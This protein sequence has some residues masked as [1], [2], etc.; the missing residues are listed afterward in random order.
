MKQTK[1]VLVLL[2]VL[3]VLSACS[4]NESD[5]NNL[6]NYKKH[7]LLLDVKLEA[8]IFFSTYD[9]EVYIDDNKVGNIKQGGSFKNSYSLNDGEHELSFNKSGDRDVNG[10]ISI[11]VDEDKAFLCNLK[12]HRDGIDINDQVEE[13]L[14]EYNIKAEKNKTEPSKTETTKPTESESE[15]I[16]KQLNALSGK[17]LSSVLEKTRIKGYKTKYIATNTGHDLT[18]DIDDIAY[19]MYFKSA[20]VNGKKKIITVKIT[21]KFIIEDRKKEKKL[22][23]KL[24]KYDAWVAAE[25]H[26]KS[27]YKKFNLHYI[28]SP[29]RA[30][31]NKDGT[32]WLLKAPCTINGLKFTCEATV[33]GT[34]DYP[35]IIDF[36]VY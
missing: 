22:S 12:A 27:L 19:S 8:N 13:T 16:E 36:I 14:K 25:Y 32:A 35:D 5:K 10:S 26:G 34:R 1:L 11:S 7:T 18:M 17:K 31:V 2:I 6:K 24:D 9:V 21:P 28:K 4:G 33:G 3:L 23:K 30:D 15:K 20:K 29:L